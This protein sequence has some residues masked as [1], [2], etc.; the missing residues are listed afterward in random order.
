MI[1]AKE[2]RSISSRLQ[3]VRIHEAMG[4]DE[5]ALVRVEEVL[6][7]DDGYGKGYATKGT[8]LYRQGNHAEAIPALKTALKYDQR[9]AQLHLRLGFSL[10]GVHEWEAAIRSFERLLAI[11]PSSGDAHVGI[12]KAR[13]KMRALAEGESQLNRAR[14]LGADERLVRQIQRLLRETRERE[15]KRREAAGEG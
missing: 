15:E 6:E 8:I 1:I 9:D 12:A 4:D 2:P 13:I 7:I 14:E 11:D 5:A 3:L 10:L